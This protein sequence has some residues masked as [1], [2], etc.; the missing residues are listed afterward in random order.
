VERAMFGIN[1][2]A[3]LCDGIFDKEKDDNSMTNVAGA[4]G[5]EATGDDDLESELAGK[6]AFVASPALVK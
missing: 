6:V 5:I 3:S 1:I 4:V 2:P